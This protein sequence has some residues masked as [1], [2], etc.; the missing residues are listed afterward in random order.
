MPLSRARPAGV[1]EYDRSFIERSG[2]QTLEELL[3][4]GIIRLLPH[5]RAVA[6]RPGQRQARTPPPAATWN[7]CPSRPSNASRFSRR[8]PGH[9]RRRHAARRAQCRAPEG[10]DGFETR[11]SRGCRAGPA[12]T[13][14]RAAFSGAAGS[15]T[16]GGMTLGVDVIDRQEIPGSSRVHSR[17]R[18][19]QGRNF[20]Q[21]RNV[22]VSGNTVFVVKLDQDGERELGEDGEPLE[23]RSV[24]LG[25]CDPADG[26]VRG[27]STRPASPPVTWAALAYGDIWWD[28]SSREQR[29]AILNL[30][31]PLGDD[32]EL[33]L[34][35]NLT[36]YETGFQYAPSVDA[37][38]SI[39][40]HR[41]RQ[42]RP[43]RL[44]G[45][46]Q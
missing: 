34:D 8:Q 25:T 31:H 3:D 41:Q 28:T 40:R 5:R 13:A 17:S 44:A 32:A 23:K 29:S 12:A 18:M 30:D 42:R 14:C 4:T 46:D 24:A 45:S 35:V 20:S 21:A 15:A 16:V 26:Y 1:V 6:A 27:L 33:H 36:Q 43:T 7:P 22:S 19:G 9:S 39:C 2:A 37:S 11:T 38:P 10:S